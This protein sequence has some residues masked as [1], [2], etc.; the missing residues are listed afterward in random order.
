MKLN[1]NDVRDLFLEYGASGKTIPQLKLSVEWRTGGTDGGNCWSD[2]G[3]YSIEGDIEPSDWSLETLLEKEFK[4]ILFL[5]YKELIKNHIKYDNRTYHEYYGNYTEYA[6]KII[7]F[8]AF[9]N[10]MKG[11]GYVD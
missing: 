5:D 10:F 8:E 7:Y 9:Y 3:H 11:K 4:D 6:N 2:G 1:Y